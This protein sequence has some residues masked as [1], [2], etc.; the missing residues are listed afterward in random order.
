MTSSTG[1][2]R[3]RL[4]LSRLLPGG[5]SGRYSDPEER[6]QRFVTLG[7]IGLIVAIAV[8]VILALLY[9]FWDSNFRPLA[10]VGGVGISRGEFDDRVRLED[11][12]LTRAEGDVRTALA[13][14]AVDPA[15]ANTRLT[16]I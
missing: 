6:F 4:S 10:S 3:R 14:G 5:S 9:G 11:F 16:A 2:R 1:P 15:V 12:R 7:F 13:D 8:I